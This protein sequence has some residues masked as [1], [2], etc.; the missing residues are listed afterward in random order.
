MY[1]CSISGI[2]GSSGSKSVIRACHS[3]DCTEWFGEYNEPGI[4]NKNEFRPFWIEYIEG[5]V[6]VGKGG[7]QTAFSQWDAGACHGRVT[8][9]VYV[10]ISGAR[11]HDDY[12]VFNTTYICE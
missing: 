5:V 7:Q 8:S 11:N 9:E 2:G 12:W 10:G 4:V 6:R 3:D 1:V